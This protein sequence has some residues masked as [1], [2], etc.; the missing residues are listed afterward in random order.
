MTTGRMGVNMPEAIKLGSERQLFIDDYCI[1]SLRGTRK[2]FHQA[3]KHPANPILTPREPWE[4]SYVQVYGNVLYD[5]DMQVYRMWYSARYEPDGPGS[6]YNTVCHATSTDGLNWERTPLNRLKHKG[7]LLSNAVLQGFN[8]IGPTVFHTPD[9]P[10]PGRRYRMF[11][12]T[13][14]VILGHPDRTAPFSQHFSVLFSPD[15]FEW[16]PYEKNPVVQGGD[17]ATCMY[18]PVTEEYIAF[19]RI[20]RDDDGRD[21][22]CV[23]V[24]VSKDFLTWLTPNIILSADAVDDARVEARLSRFRNLLVFDDP[25][26]YSADMQGMTGFRCEGLRL[27]LI[28]FYDRSSRRPQEF[29]GNDDGILNIQLAYSRNTNPYL[30]WKRAGDR[31]DFI[32]CGAEGAYDGGCMWTAHAV[33]ERDDELWFYYTAN[34]HSHGYWP[35]LEAVYGS[36]MPNSILSRKPML[37]TSINLAT[38]RLDGFASIEALYP[39]GSMTTKLLTFDGE[40]LVI[41]AYAEK[42]HILVELIDHEGKPIPGYTKEE[43]IPFSRDDIR[44]EVRWKE[45]SR[46]SPLRGKPVHM[47]FHLK[48]AQLYSFGVS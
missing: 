36:D 45:R 4:A 27:G 19:P 8:V 10:D 22:R 40:R 1:G 23:A 39:P 12:Y 13:D 35:E 44:G 11:I 16:T 15:G 6:K 14:A 18:D 29:K 32:P 17:I 7:L 9:D 28:W 26:F 31:Y 25:N 43:S 34:S 48:T 21:R 38:L 47:V 42:G 37:P 24:S 41:N 20:H 5:P 3:Q 30:G 2:R 46:L 33:L